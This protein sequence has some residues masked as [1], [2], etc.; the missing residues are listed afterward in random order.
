MMTT[1][2]VTT[3]IGWNDDPNTDDVNY[4]DRELREEEESSRTRVVGY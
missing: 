3:V 2:M 4:D 1:Y